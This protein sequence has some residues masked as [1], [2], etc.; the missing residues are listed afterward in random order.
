MPRYMASTTFNE[1]GTSGL[2]GS[3]FAARR[4]WLRDW[5]AQGGGTLESVYFLSS[6]EMVVIASFDEPQ[7]N[8]RVNFQAM[9]SGA[10]LRPAD[11]Q[12]IYTGEEMDAALAQQAVA[13]RPP[14]S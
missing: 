11:F 5:T 14:G 13:Y 9:A 8:A 12:V 4:A 1:V 6:G 7:N 2:L 10:L 3:G